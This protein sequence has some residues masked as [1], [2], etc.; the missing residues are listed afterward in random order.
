MIAFHNSLIEIPE[1]GR[2]SL[3]EVLWLA[4]GIMA[5]T[6]ATLRLKPLWIDYQITKRLDHEDLC[7]ISFGYLR[8]EVLRIVSAL[9]IVVVGVYTCATNSAVPGPSRISVTG[10]VIT[11]SLFII[12]LAVSAQSILDWRD[13]NKTIAIVTKRNE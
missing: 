3:V 6:F 5:L 4:S 8:R 11:A 2:V 9:S 10:L 1:W 13:R 7:I 12:S